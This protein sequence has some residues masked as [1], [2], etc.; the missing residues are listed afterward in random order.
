MT[1]YTVPFTTGTDKRLQFDAVNRHLSVY[2][3][4]V[5]NKNRESLVR[6]REQ[7]FPLQYYSRLSILWQAHVH[8][9][10]TLSQNRYNFCS[11]TQHWKNWQSKVKKSAESEFG[12]W[13]GK[14]PGV[15]TCTRMAGIRG[16]ASILAGELLVEGWGFLRW[17]PGNFMSIM[18]KSYY[19]GS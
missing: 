10:T 2:N 15:D 8:E 16:V 3:Q 19:L 14:Y 1:R 5:G 9:N 6:Q 4:V 12:L 13:G 11:E 7:W 18:S 17:W